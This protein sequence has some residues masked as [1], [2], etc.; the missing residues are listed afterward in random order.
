MHSL[1]F[2][3]GFL[4][5]ILENQKDDFEIEKHPPTFEHFCLCHVR[6]YFEIYYCGYVNWQTELNCVNKEERTLTQFLSGNEKLEETWYTY[7]RSPFFRLATQILIQF[8][9]LV[10]E[11]NL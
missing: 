3:V 11:L 2:V 9:S 4:I 8:L 6:T 5:S 10:C 7:V 1:F